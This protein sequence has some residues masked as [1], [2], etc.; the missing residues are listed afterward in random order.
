MTFPRI[1]EDTSILARLTGAVFI[2]YLAIGIPLPVI[3][4]WVRH[5]LHLSDAMVGLA[6]GLQFLATVL[7]RGYAG[8]IAD[9]QGARRA[10][11]R[12][13]VT[14]SGAGIVYA[15]TVLLPLPVAAQ[16]ALLLFGR[17]VMGY[18][19]S[20]ILTGTLAWGIALLGGNKSGRVMSWNGMAMYLAMT[21]GAPIGMF[22]YERWGFLSIGLLVICCPLLGFLSNASVQTVAPRPGKRLSLLSVIGLLWKFGVAMALHNVGFIMIGTF[23]SLYFSEN[24]WSNAGIAIS[25]FGAA[26]VLVRALFNTLPD[27]VGGIPVATVSFLIEIAGQLVIWTAGSSYMVWFGCALTGLGCSLIFPALGVEVIKRVPSQMHGTAIGSYSAFVDITFLTANPLAGV[28]AG[29]AG[30]ASV[31]LGGAVCALIG[32][33]LVLALGYGIRK[34]NAATPY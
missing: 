6:I 10:A 26:Y 34:N 5:E 16:F 21:V 27:R 24:N 13:I 4:L 12:G 22:F 8:K 2:V 31:Y 9:N 25:C 30:Y 7:T 1:S 23:M 15:A 20:M 29:V 3:P 32:L 28:L 18:G 17:L 11:W 14:C 33:F 19:E